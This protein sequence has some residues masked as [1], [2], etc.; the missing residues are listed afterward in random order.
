MCLCVWRHV[1]LWVR[2]SACMCVWMRVCVCEGM[3]VC[4]WVRV[5]ECMYVRVNARVCVW[6]H[7]CVCV[8]M[9]VRTR[10]CVRVCVCVL[11]ARPCARAGVWWI[12]TSECLP[13]NTRLQCSCLASV[14]LLTGLNISSAIPYMEIN[15]EQ[16]EKERGM[17]LR[18]VHHTEE[19]RVR[20]WE[21]KER[22]WKWMD[23]NSSA[24]FWVDN[25]EKSR[26][27]GQVWGKENKYPEK[28][29]ESERET[30]REREKG[31]EGATTG[32][33]QSATGQPQP[34]YITACCHCGRGHRS[35]VTLITLRPYE[36]R[37][38]F[39]IP[40][41]KNLNK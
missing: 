4:V 37:F 21:N 16:G 19:E 27:L 5:S 25:F 34:T 8:W 26:E 38:A 7:V 17:D 20:V 35:A 41:L 10:V 3:C 14:S 23:K 31:R 39:L 28:G 40:L 13:K 1:C 9:C 15:L 11:W 33:W 24:V 12:V 36:I 30:A 2:V 32:Q 29:K 6:M 22:I 18:P